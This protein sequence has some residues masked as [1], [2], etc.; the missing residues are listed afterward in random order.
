VNETE[1]NRLGV[2][3]DTLMEAVAVLDAEVSD[4]K[5]TE[6]KRWTGRVETSVRNRLKELKRS[7]E[8]NFERKMAAEMNEVADSNESVEEYVRRTFGGQLEATDLGKV[9]VNISDV[10]ERVPLVPMWVPSSFLPFIINSKTSTLGPEQVEAIKDDV[11][12]GSRFYVTSFE[13]VPG[14]ALFR[15]NIRTP[16]GGVD[17]DDGKNQTAMVFDDIQD[18]L[19]QKGLDGK[20]QLFLMPDPEWHPTRNEREPE[21]KPVILALSKAVTPDESKIDTGAV[22][23]TGRVSVQVAVR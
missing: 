12:F 15:G 19:E 8:L 13:S 10:L 20:V 17:T 9:D 14:A 18:R 6:N 21:P 7:Q 23:V 22:L 4:G 1:Y 3:L 11:L 16:K 5:Q 2:V